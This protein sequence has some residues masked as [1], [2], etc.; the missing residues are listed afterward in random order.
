VITP[1]HLSDLQIQKD[2]W[3]TYSIYFNDFVKEM[4][5]SKKKI[6]LSSDKKREFKN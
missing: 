3:D 1:K 2:V 6:S 4:V 5:N